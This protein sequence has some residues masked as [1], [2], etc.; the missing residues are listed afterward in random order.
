MIF[1]ESLESMPCKA[2]CF[3]LKKE[4][5]TCWIERSRSKCL[6]FS[7]SDCAAVTVVIKTEF[8][9]ADLNCRRRVLA[10]KFYKNDGADILNK[11]PDELPV[12]I[13]LSAHEGWKMNH[14]KLRR[15]ES[16]DFPILGVANAH[17]L[18][19]NHPS[20]TAGSFCAA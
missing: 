7:F 3:C 9:L 10:K 19:N 15:R 16:I 14:R 2:L 17:Q 1:K 5:D 11:T 18:A 13:R 20:S 12:S 8:N 6:A 4:G